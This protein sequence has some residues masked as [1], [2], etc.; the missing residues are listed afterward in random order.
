[1]DLRWVT[2]MEEARRQIRDTNFTTHGTQ[3]GPI[4]NGL[5]L[6]NISRP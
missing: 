3:V 1:M 6:T 5:Q 2:L 4:E